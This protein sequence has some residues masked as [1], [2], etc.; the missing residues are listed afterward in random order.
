MINFLLPPTGGT[1]DNVIEPSYYDLNIYTTSNI[2]LTSSFSVTPSI[3]VDGTR[4]TILWNA[5]VTLG[6]FTVTICGQTINQDQVNQ[7]G[8]FECYYDNPAWVVQYF[9]DG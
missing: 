4:F 6:G 3:N 1:L 9:A 8:T 5:D 2:I 7:S